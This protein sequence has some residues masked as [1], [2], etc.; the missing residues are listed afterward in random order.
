L[1]AVEALNLSK[2]YKK[3]QALRGLDFEVREGEIMVILGPNGSGKTTLLMILCTILK[4]TSGTARVMGFD[5]VKE[6]IKVRE[7]L[8]I[9]FQD[10]RGFW[11]HK[12]SAILRFHAAMFGVEEARRQGDIDQIL[13]DLELW[14]SKDKLFMHLSG[15]QAKR[16]ETAK[17]LIQRPKLAIFDEPTSQVDL[18]GKRTIW[19]KI[20]SL[21]DQGS[22]VIVAT[23]EVREAE[24]LADRVT[25]LHKGQRVVSDT[26][27][28]LKDAIAGGD[29]VEVDFEDPVSTRL[30]ENFNE[31]GGA[32][33]LLGEGNQLKARVSKA[34]DWVPKMTSASYAAGAKISSIRITEPSLDDVFLHFT[35]RVLEDQPR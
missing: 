15:G 10:P 14:D 6:G 5:V 22:T 28:T 11:R 3:S 12:P 34:E 9:G 30:A 21:R 16:L 19:D 20:K 23:N 29:V 27:P 8:G 18:R 7:I 1:P 26:I 24:Y 33:Q 17:V 35:G 31:L 13:K 2:K 25:I 32:V 4:P